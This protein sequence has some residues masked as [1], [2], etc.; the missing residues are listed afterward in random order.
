MNTEDAEGALASTELGSEG[1]SFKTW[2][3]SATLFGTLTEIG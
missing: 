2:P 3:I 1:V